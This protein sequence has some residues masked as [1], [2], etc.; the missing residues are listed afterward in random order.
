MLVTLY[1]STLFTDLNTSGAYDTGQGEAFVGISN[2]QVAYV[3]GTIPAQYSSIG[4]VEG[5]NAIDLS[6]DYPQLGSITSIPIEANYLPVDSIAISGTATGS[7]GLALVPRTALIGIPVTSVLSDGSLVANWSMSITGMPPADHMERLTEDP[8]SAFAGASGAIELPVSYTDSDSSGGWTYA[9]THSYA[10][11]I[12]GS[13]VYL[14]YVYLS[15]VE[16]IYMYNQHGGPAGWLGVTDFYTNPTVT[17]NL[18]GAV[19]D[20][21]CAIT[22]Q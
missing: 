1:T 15:S 18:T 22:T 5:W 14:V 8:N 7:G 10:A 20:S 2:M 11:C 6:G 4:I 16:D 3:T 13:P 19:L 21:S 17:S 9:D 12:G